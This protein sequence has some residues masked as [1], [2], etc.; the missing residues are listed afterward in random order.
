M[1]RKK[2]AFTLIELSIVLI[3]IGLV[4]GALVGGQ[5]LIKSSQLKSARQLSNSA[6]LFSKKGSHLIMWLDAT[7]RDAFNNVNIQNGDDV[8]KW[9][10]V[11]KTQ[12]SNLRF[13]A[14]E[15][16]NPPS[17]L[18]DGINSLPSIDFNGTSD[19]I[20]TTRTFNPQTPF[21]LFLV[22][23]LNQSDSEVYQYF[24][25]LFSNSSRIYIASDDSS[26]FYY[27]VGDVHSTGTL[28]D[29]D[30]DPHI[31]SLRSQGGSSSVTTESF[32]DGSSNGTRD[33]EINS[34][35]DIFSIGS[36]GSVSFLNGQIGEVIMF[37]TALHDN[38]IDEIEFYLSQKWSIPLN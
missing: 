10:D 9:N 17:Y 1:L 14:N 27:T 30:T 18:R 26:K 21:T 7:S 37:N 36:A 33:V 34:A 28:P 16:T 12:I 22:G 3:I 15:L 23:R 35:N 32:F 31:F 19:R 13:H 5:S 38:E 20:S 4:V 24:F 29:S 25:R 8:T 11:N 2:S 6:P